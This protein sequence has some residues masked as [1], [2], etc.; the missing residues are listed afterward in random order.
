MA[1]KQS[2]RDAQKEVQLKVRLS[3][4]E[5]KDVRV[6]AAEMELTISEFLRAAV[7]AYTQRG[8]AEYVQR[9]MT[10]AGRKPSGE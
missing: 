2:S 5:H 4:E 7:L 1:K 3:P 10:K 9:G 6:A 8:V